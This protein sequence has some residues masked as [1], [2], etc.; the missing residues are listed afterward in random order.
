MKILFTGGSSFTGYW[1]VRSLAE[2]GHHVFTVFQQLSENYSGIR[3]ARV[4]G[5][6]KISQPVFGCSFGSSEMLR[7]IERESAWDLVCH[8]AA[9]VANYK[10]PDFDVAG[11]LAQNTW[12]LPA[13]LKALQA[14][15]CNKVLLTGSIFEQDEGAPSD[16]SRAFSPYGLSKGLTYQIFRYYAE[17][18]Q[19][20]LGKFVIPNPFGPYEEPR[21]T[22]Y[23][24]NSWKEGKVP[25]VSTPAYI[26][27]NIHVDL[28]ANA[29]A[30][31][32]EKLNEDAGFDFL[33][34]SGYAESQGDFTKRFSGEMGK[35]LP[36]GCPFDLAEQ[37]DFSEP[38][39]RINTDRLDAQTYDWNEEAAW[40]NLAR[41]YST[42][43]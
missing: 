31:F 34:P 24:I 30:A 4:D 38:R 28:L 41:Y 9:V 5:L 7:L 32:A 27:D 39:V 13:V 29:Y 11:A 19:M 21:F 2:A 26:R 42:G 18:L 15:G 16:T 20:R 37:A 25:K 40:D 17:I 36:F 23:L 12:N 8:H 3:K 35:R 22:A 14:K 1:F 33:H 43:R 10:S 6:L